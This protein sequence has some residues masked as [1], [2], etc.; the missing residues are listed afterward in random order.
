MDD[1]P[2]SDD[3]LMGFVFGYQDPENFY[4]FDWKA[5]P[6]N[7]FGG[8]ALRGMSIKRVTADSPLTAA[9]L[10]I[11]AGN[12]ERVETLF[13]NPLAWKIETDYEFELDFVPGQFTIAISEGDT[14][15]E[16]VTIE[17][18]TF[19]DGKFG[20]YNN[21]QSDV[22]YSGF[23][24]QTIPLSN[25]AYDVDAIDPDADPLSFSLIEGPRGMAIDPTSG[26]LSW[27]ATEDNLGQQAVTVAVED[28]RGGI[29]TQSYL[30]EVNNIPP[31]EIRGQVR[32]EG[33]FDPAGPVRVTIPGTSNPWLAGMPDGSTASSGD[34][35]PDQ[36]PVFVEDLDLNGVATLLF[37]ASGA[38]N[39]V[40]SLPSPNATS[41]GGSLTPHFSRAQNGIGDVTAPVNGLI[42][43]FLTDEQPDATPAPTESLNFNPSTGNVDNGIN[44]DSITPLL[45]QPFFI[46]DGFTEDGS[47]QEV[48]VPTGAT[49]LFLGSMDGFGWFNNSGEMDVE[50]AAV[51][52]GQNLIANGD[53]SLGDF[54]FEADRADIPVFDVGTDPQDFNGL[55]SSYGDHT[56][57][58]GNM[59][60][61]NGSFT[62]PTVVWEQTI[63]VQENVLYD[64]SLWSS[65]WF[66]ASPA[67]F[68]V[69]VNGEVIDS[70]QA[71]ETTAVWE[72]FTT[73]WNA[74][75]GIVEATISIVNQQVAFTGNDF[76]FDDLFFGARTGSEALD[77][78]TV[79][80]DSNNN[81]V[82]DSNEQAQ[83][84]DETGR[85]RFGGLAP[86]DY[87]VRQLPPR[88]F[89]Q[90]QPG[91]AEPN[92]VSLEAGEVE[93]GVDF[94]I[95]PI[96]IADNSDPVLLS[97][98]PSSSIEIGERFT[99]QILAKD[100]NG[101]PLTYD[102][103][104]APEG[105]VID[106]ETGV[107][108]WVPNAEQTGDN[109]VIT[110]VRDDFGG[111]VL[112]RFSLDV[113]LPNTDPVIVSSPPQ[114]AA[115]GVPLVYGV[116]AQ[117]SEEDE[118]TYSLLNAPDGA[119]I[120]P[121]GQLGWTPLAGQEG[122]QSF[123]I[124]VGDGRGGSA[125]QAFEIDARSTLPNQAPQIT[126]S[127]RT[128]LRV[129]DRYL[130][131]VEA[132][133]PDFE[134]L[135]Y[136]LST[137]P[138]GM[139]ISERGLVEWDS[140]GSALGAYPVALVV[141]D[142]R[143][144]AA[145]QAFDLQVL[146]T[147]TNRAPVFTST[148]PVIAIAGQ[149]FR[150]QPEVS[151]ADGDPVAFFPSGLFG[152]PLPAG[153]SNNP[154]TGEIR[155]TPG[156]EDLGRASFAVTASDP[157]GG[158]AT[159]VFEVEVVAGNRPPLISST[160]I[161][162]AAVGDAYAY[163]I[164]A[165]DPDGGPLTFS[166]S[167]GPRN[168]VLD[169]SILR[170]SPIAS[171]RGEQ[172]VTVE[173][174]D[175]LGAATAQS[176]TLLVTDSLPNRA[177]V[178]TSM[179]GFTAEPDKPYRYQVQAT[180]P[181]GGA[182]TFV[183]EDAPDGV[184]LDPTTGLLEWT[185]TPAQIGLANISLKA[186]DP[187]GLGLIQSYS[188]AVAVNNPPEISSTPPLQ[189]T[190]G[191]DYS[192]DLL[193][194]D[195]DGGQLGY[196]LLEAPDGMTIDNFGRLRWPTSSA[197]IGR[198][199]V[200]VVV[201]DNGGA[202]AEQAFELEVVA[203]T[204]APSISILQNNTVVERGETVTFQ[205]RATDDVGVDSISFSVGGR[206]IGLDANGQANV[207]LDGLGPVVA[208]ATATD[209]AGNTGSA[210]AT[211]QA[212]DSSD[213]DAP[214]VSITS[215]SD[216]D[217]I[218]SPIDVIGSVTDDNLISY[219]LSVARAGGGPFREI[220]TGSD[221]VMDG[222]VGRFDPTLLEN[223][224]Y[225]LRLSATD[226]GGNVSTTERQVNLDGQL[227]LGNFQLSF[228]DLSIP[229]AGI[230]ITVSRTYDTL[231]ADTSDDLGFGWSLG[232][233][234]T[235]LR[236]DVPPFRAGSK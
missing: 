148:P 70:F 97:E 205:V 201:A 22:L 207:V 123:S 196:Q 49:R 159:Q 101:D 113:L 182:L 152:Q 145:E 55:A 71:P 17:D 115:I 197:V 121:L 73:Q 175:A 147:A 191:A 129:G 104:L 221:V 79:F 41:D 62:Q 130:Y 96:E 102:L 111:V 56:S 108:A 179:P 7:G 173:A 209:A 88:G 63:P 190:A 144:E 54:G 32:G 75:P 210:E 11:T 227:K 178:I 105:M 163:A 9:D 198:A 12:G 229:V 69:L 176:F 1:I 136:A 5:S 29:D 157:Y 195:A 10:W 24:R 132:N 139:T 228:V 87:L 131:Q 47:R 184:S 90:I 181:E 208:T 34:V 40:P 45:K 36:S 180:D 20:F 67:N 177:P 186:Q 231:Q 200:R 120:S 211:A 125:A 57:G 27:F 109:V 42:G 6:Q 234:D 167:R 100:G 74:D 46:G 89:E 202:T 64:F 44:Y 81:T 116:L 52:P 66:P 37:A 112:Q 25:Y 203:D 118:L 2:P 8:S 51:T 153:A 212:I 95:Q 222:A 168:M 166:L 85:Y 169:G 137:A 83:Q 192:Y 48:V 61:V 3:D 19:I 78:I 72:N 224:S 142:S 172:Q 16:S 171:Q 106:A 216:G 43:L 146:S 38:V 86:G 68:Q 165:E 233:F 50:I 151:D 99:A 230:P 21:S 161:T 127:P 60:I 30:L 156:F 226:A 155:W 134:A 93:T 18:D 114:L 98:V 31:G 150:Y 35:A 149:P 187:Q 188:L 59:L 76:A 128:E 199:P 80:L 65:T 235:N 117:D 223:D 135:S 217:V 133:D 140:D 28:G 39:N 164:E 58:D 215:I 53:F 124:E 103:P 170:W 158:V 23:R 13:R 204:Q 183:L 91:D 77:G 84:T 15:L 219:S 141:T 174:I 214:V 194:S 218:T 236:T 213:V 160:P 26:A 225:I 143:G 14:L 122:L 162:E 94:I 189:V 119:T 185:P 126:S 232:L 82:V 138:T 220:A 193:A 154:A 33:S 92:Q 206:A 4:L 107:I 110:R